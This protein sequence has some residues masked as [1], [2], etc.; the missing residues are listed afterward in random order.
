MT[1]RARN[2]AGILALL[3]LAF[4]LGACQSPPAAPGESADQDQPALSGDGR[5]LALIVDQSG[6]SSVRLIDRASGRALPLGPLDRGQPHRSPS[7]S[8]NGRYLALIRQRGERSE[9]V[10]LDRARGRLLPLPLPADRLPEKLSL[11]PDARR[12]AVQSLR[13]GRSS[14]DLLDLSGIEPDLPPGVPL[15]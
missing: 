14:V 11:A 2:P 12:L 15:R 7:L 4:L 13:D 3:A 1:Q 9:A 8:W 5:L 6:R 10:L